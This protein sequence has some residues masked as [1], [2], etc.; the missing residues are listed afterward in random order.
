[1]LLGFVYVEAKRSMQFRETG[2]AMFGSDLEVFSEQAIAY[3][4]RSFAKS[5]EAEPEIFQALGDHIAVSELEKCNGA[6]ARKYR[7]GRLGGK[8]TKAGLLH[9]EVIE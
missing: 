8:C 9:L 7:L 1:M 4:L 6:R 3:V 5:G 2:E